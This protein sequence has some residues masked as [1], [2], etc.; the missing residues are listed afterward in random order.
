MYGGFNDNNDYN[1][2]GFDDIDGSG[3]SD[4]RSPGQDKYQ[5]AMKQLD[6][7]DND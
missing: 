6:E 5:N 7:F 1:F 3:K 4:K 2:D